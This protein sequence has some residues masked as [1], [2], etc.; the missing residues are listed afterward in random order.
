MRWSIAVFL[1]VF[2]SWL[3]PAGLAAEPRV[4]EWQVP[5]PNTRPRDPYVDSA[6]RVWFCGQAG[7][8]IAHLD[9]T[10]GAFTR[11]DLADGAGPHNLI[12]DAPDRVW[13]AANTL[14]YIGRL[15]PKRGEIKKYEMPKDTARDPH[16]LVFDDAGNIWFTAQWSDRIGRLDME[17]GKI[18]LVELPGRGLRPYGIKVDPRGR[19]WAVLF[20]TNKLASID[21]A[22]L[23]LWQVEL[24]DSLSRPRRLEID[25]AGNIWYGDYSR[26]TLGRYAPDTGKFDE[27]PLPGGSNS[28]PYGMALD[29]EGRIWLAEAGS[30]NRLVAFDPGKGVFTHV[31]D[32]PNA[33]GSIRHMYFDARTDS[34]WF[35]EDSNY[36]GRL[37][38]R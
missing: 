18:D 35:G 31:I 32:V 36:I 30:P 24:P 21:P 3:P 13:Y 15:D 22:S 16:T 19:P 23:R 7:A 4:T 8:Y 10:T 2:T 27:W 1:I 34:I 14:P 25:A 12:I 28:R 17:S 26:G 33:R 6:G 37:Q 38:L 11:F 20:G 5:Y 29:S 9:P